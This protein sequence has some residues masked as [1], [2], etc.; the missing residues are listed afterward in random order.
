MKT[1][2]CERCLMN[3]TIRNVEIFNDGTCS[4]CRKY[5][6]T[7]KRIKPPYYDSIESLLWNIL[8]TDATYDI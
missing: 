2:N 1:Y 8:H 4:S 6:A 7:E 5:F 3:T